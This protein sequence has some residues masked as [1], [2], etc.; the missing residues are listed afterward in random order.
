MI[1]VTIS[2]C[3]L[4]LS[5]KDVYVTVYRTWPRYLWLVLDWRHVFFKLQNN[6]VWNLILLRSIVVITFIM[7]TYS[8]LL[9]NDL[10]PMIWQ[11]CNHKRSNSKDWGKTNMHLLLILFF[12]S[13]KAQINSRLLSNCQNIVFHKIYSNLYILLALWSFQSLARSF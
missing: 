3:N 12:F 5:L 9:T 2:P 6:V 8:H 7:Y 4:I 10:H 11:V 1:H 13:D